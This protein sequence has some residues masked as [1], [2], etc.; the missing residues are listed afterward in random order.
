MIKRLLA[1]RTAPLISLAFLML[2]IP[3]RTRANAEVSLFAQD[4]LMKDT[5]DAKGLEILNRINSIAAPKEVRD[6]FMIKKAQVAPFVSLQ[7]FL[8]GNIAGLSVQENT[9]EPGAVQS[10]VLRG[11]AAPVFNAKDVYNQQPIVYL[12]GVPLVQDHPFAYDIQK[13]D[14]NRIGP[15]TNLLSSLDPSN[16][17]TI[18]VIKD[19]LELA[20]LGSLAANGAIWI[21]TKNAQ[22]G[23]REISINSYFGMTVPESIT[24]TN[25]D[26]EDRFRQP[27]YAKYAGTQEKL[28]YA[29]YL[30]DSTNADYYGPSQWGKLY[31]QSQPSYA[32]DMSLTGGSE[33]ANFRFFGSAL[34]N[35]ASADDTNLKRYNASFYI[36]MAPFEWLTVSSM[37]NAVRLDRDRNRSMRDRYA[38]TRYLPDLTTP[39]PPNKDLY[40]SYINEYDKAIDDNLNNVAQGYLALNFKLSDKINYVSRLSFDYNEG[41][42]DVFWPSTLMETNN[43]VSNYFGYNQRLVFSNLVSF[44]NQFSQ[45]HSLDFE[46]GQSYWSD[47]HKYNYATAYDGPNDFIKVNVVEGDPNSGSYLSPIGFHV[48]RYNDR[49]RLTMLSFHGSAKYHYDDFL[50]VS[51]LLRTDGSSNLQPDQRWFISPALSASVR[52]EKFIESSQLDML[53][54][55]FSAARIGQTFQTDRF[56]FGPQYRVDMGWSQEPSM[57]SYN[58]IAGISRPYSDG[59]VDYDIENPFSDQ[60]EVNLDMAFF[61]HRLNVSASLYSKTQKNTVLRIPV[62][63]EY[64]YTGKY[65]SGMDVNN[66][67]L[68]LLLGMDVGRRKL[69]WHTSLNL[70]LNRNSLQALPGGLDEIVI[71]QRQLRVGEPIDRFWLLE[72]HGIYQTGNDIPVNP[73]NNQPLAYRNIQMNAGDPRWV[74]QN[75]DFQID[76]QDRVLKGNALPYLSGGWANDFKYKR[77]NLNFQFFFAL[78][79]DALNS[80]ASSQYD[81]INREQSNDINSIKEIYSWQQRVDI[82]K[83]PIYNPWSPVVPYRIEQDLFLENASYLKLRTLVLGYDLGDSPLFKNAGDAFKR[84]YIYAT[85]ANL[86]TISPFSGSDPELVNL[87]GQY[88]GYGLPI[89]KT[90]MLGLKIDL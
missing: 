56:A 47:V 35:A 2:T 85:G 41:L 20:K 52:L 3:M 78:G 58:A 64:G 54:L 65:A 62:P 5:L 84:V 38:E 63:L 21:T 67:G 1:L 82:S 19:P 42:R 72:N 60:L 10:M 71:G 16:I 9:G 70:N 30:R 28:N 22:S 68:D 33:R 49:E 51:A 76:D 89:P 29:A 88:S 34:Q 8:K 7:Q 53:N 90:F 6:S 55:T 17:N 26:Y 11:L 27:F 39:L 83:Y 25:A 80:E 40:Q 37:I 57:F 23:Y 66:K 43:F 13:Y 48:Y 12:N 79:Q 74:D 24:P 14:Y 4:T 86:L 87:M 61:D 59:W 18:E 81:F 77:W 75:G 73:V 46:A 31:Y 45:M 50:S 32:V 15:A 44:R 36:N 69:G